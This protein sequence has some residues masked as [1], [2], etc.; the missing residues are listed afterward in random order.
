MAQS[1]RTGVVMGMAAAVAA[2]GLAIALRANAAGEAAL[3]YSDGALQAGAAKAATC[4]ACHGPSGNSTNPD[5]PKLAG[6]NAI[7]LAEQLHLFKAAVRN[8]AVGQ[9]HRRCG[10]VL[11]GPDARGGRG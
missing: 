2:C 3:P 6:Q 9:G 1:M 4:T 10:G 5:W 8:N 7:Y 11:R